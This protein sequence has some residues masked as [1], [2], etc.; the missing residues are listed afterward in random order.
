MTPI[1]PSPATP[2]AGDVPPH[3]DGGKVEPVVWLLF[4]GTIFF[5][6][7]TILISK[8]SPNDGQTFQVVSNM[9]AGFF[10][11]LMLRIRVG[12]GTKK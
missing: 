2:D 3:D 7:L 12:G 4:F 9:A 1:D 8:W 5:A 10:S 6:G 11:C